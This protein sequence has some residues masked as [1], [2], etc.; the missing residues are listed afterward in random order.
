MMAYYVNLLNHEIKRR[1]YCLNLKT[2][3]NEDS[4]FLN[5]QVESVF[6]ETFTATL[7]LSKIVTFTLV[8]CE[9]T[10]LGFYF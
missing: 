2:S 1:L 5:V 7:R 8:R 3:S 4:K 9:V 6:G 10:R